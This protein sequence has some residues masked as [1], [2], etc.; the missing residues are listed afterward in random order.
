MDAAYAEV[1]G[2]HRP[3]RTVFSVQELP[4]ARRLAHDEFDCG[5][6]GAMTRQATLMRPRSPGSLD[7]IV[8][9]LQDLQGHIEIERLRGLEVNHYFELGWI[10]NGQVGWPCP[11]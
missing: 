1:M 9:E 10:L 3:A 2:A 4:Q 6:E 11:F 7:Q 8:G 5:D